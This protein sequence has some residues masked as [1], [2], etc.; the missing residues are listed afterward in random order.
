M[1]HSKTHKK[2]VARN[3]ARRLKKEA[4]SD[5]C[6]DDRLLLKEVSLKPVEETKDIPKEDKILKK[7]E[8]L[9]E[10]SRI[11]SYLSPPET[12]QETLPVIT[13]PSVIITPKKESVQSKVEPKPI[14]GTRSIFPLTII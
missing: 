1:F 11:T 7:E 5:I 2:N 6:V 9:P 14:P 12:K 10:D 13:T 4:V 3:K 8:N